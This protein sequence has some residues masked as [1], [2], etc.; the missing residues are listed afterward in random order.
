LTPN[1]KI[2]V[3]KLIAL[4]PPRTERAHVSDEPLTEMERAL[5]DT[6]KEALKLDT[7]SVHDNFFEL[8]GHSLLSIQVIARLG[9]KIGIRIDPREFTY[10]TL[11]QMA[12]SLEQQTPKLSPSGG[13]SDKPGLLQ[14]LKRKILGASRRQ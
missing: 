4:E 8:G 3:K 6:W 9:K 12:A 5:A 13:R 14:A 1:R 10:Q 11:G 7:I 2:D